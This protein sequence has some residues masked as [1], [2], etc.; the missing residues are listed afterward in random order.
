[1]KTT[2]IREMKH[3]AANYSIRKKATGYRIDSYSLTITAIYD[4]LRRKLIKT[5][6]KRGH[7]LFVIPA[8]HFYEVNGCL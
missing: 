2:R 5:I 3:I 1:M 6:R 4:L 7:F 8:K